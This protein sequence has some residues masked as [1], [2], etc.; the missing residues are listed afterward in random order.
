MDVVERNFQVF[1]NKQTTQCFLRDQSFR[2]EHQSNLIVHC[3]V[4]KSGTLPYQIIHSES[5]QVGTFTR[6]YFSFDF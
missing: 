3:Y 5:G 1:E 6:F 2:V 4:F